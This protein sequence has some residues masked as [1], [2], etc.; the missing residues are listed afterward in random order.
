MAD[1]GRRARA[2]GAP[3]DLRWLIDPIDPQRFRRQYWEKQPLLV[4]RR[5]RDYY[6][7]LLSLAEVDAMLSSSSIRAPQIRVVRQGRDLPFGRHENQGVS[8]PARML[9]L[10]YGEYRSGATIVLQFL[11]ERWDPLARLCRTLGAEFSAAFQTNA[12]LTPAGEQ[13]LLTTTR[14]TCSSCRPP[15]RST[16]GSS[17]RRPSRCRLAASRSIGM[18]SRLAGWPANSTSSRATSCTSRGAG[19]TTR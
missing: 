15:A 19:C 17:S 10:L 5:R 8:A 16:G 13:G 18:R 4:S 6:E 1:R 12:Y 11:H 3:G 14:T 9:E 2:P 7:S